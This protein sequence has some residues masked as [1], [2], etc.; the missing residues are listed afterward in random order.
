MQPFWLEIL[1]IDVQI[2][3]SGPEVIKPF[4]HAQLNQY[5]RQYLHV[6][7]QLADYISMDYSLGTLP[8]S[9]FEYD[10]LSW[11]QLYNWVLVLCNY[12]YIEYLG[13]DQSMT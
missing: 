2:L 9:L 3:A 12:G 4:F 10:L 5:V 7:A 1:W 11:I 6:D 13:V 8:M